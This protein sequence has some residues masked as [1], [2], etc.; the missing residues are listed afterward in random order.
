MKKIKTYIPVIILAFM[1]TATGMIKAQ[2]EDNNTKTFLEQLACR[3]QD[4]EVAPL[5][6]NTA[7]IASEVLFQRLEKEYF[8]NDEEQVAPLP[9]E[10]TQVAYNNALK[11]AWAL[12]SVVPEEPE[13]NDFSPVVKK[14]MTNNQKTL[15]VQTRK[16]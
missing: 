3:Q 2:P 1:M 12:A 5:P 10:V 9:P 7:Q 11:K 4:E 15:L 14:F 6:F 8:S 16:K 13:V